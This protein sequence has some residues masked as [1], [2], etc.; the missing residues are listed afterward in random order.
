MV[1]PDLWIL[2]L[3]KVGRLCLDEG[4]QYRLGY[5]SLHL[6]LEV[7][8]D[9]SVTLVAILVKALVFDNI[10]SQADSIWRL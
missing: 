1:L 4:F 2:R 5:I 6:V 7:G 10:P 3:Q 9:K 8:I